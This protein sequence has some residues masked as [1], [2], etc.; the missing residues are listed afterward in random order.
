MTEAGFQPFAGGW[1]I[2][3]DPDDEKDYERDWSDWL[4]LSGD[5]TI[6][7]VSW[8]VDDGLVVVTAK[9]SNTTTAA[10]VWLS[11]GTAGRNYNVTCRITTAGGRT[12]DSS[13]EVRCRSK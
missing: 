6:A 4:A 5:D 8:V 11:G 9:N 1:W 7:S 3:K 10:T 2:A 13:F 12:C